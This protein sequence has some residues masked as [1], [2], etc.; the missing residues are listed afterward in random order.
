M[1]KY[2]Q[3]AIAL[4]NSDL[5][6]SSAIY[7]LI[8]FVNKA[9]PFFL[10]PL[11]TRAFSL[12]EYGVFSIYRA[13]MN[14]SIPIVGLSLAEAVIR[15]YYEK[16]KVD[17][18]TYIFSVLFIN[19]LTIGSLLLITMVWGTELYGITR[20]SKELIIMALLISFFTSINN[21]ERGLFRCEKQNKLFGV[22]VVGQ[23]LLYFVLIFLLYFIHRLVLVNAVYAEVSVYAIFAVIGLFY[24]FKKYDIKPVISKAYIKTALSFSLPLV[25]NGIMAYIF[26]LSD[27]YII[28][29]QLG[30]KSVAIYSATFQ[31]TSVLQ[32]LA[33]SFITAWLHWIYESLNKKIAIL[34]LLK[35]QLAISFAFVIVGILFYIV[36][37]RFLP[38]IVGEK[39]KA[40][41]ILIG[42]FIGSNLLQALYQMFAPILQYYNKGWFLLMA[43]IP[44]FLFSVISNT[45]YLKNYGIV[46]ASKI[47]FISW[48]VIFFITL[49]CS[50][51]V[52][53]NAYKQSN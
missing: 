46:F 33:A 3:K 45:L 11:F 32:I 44:A 12:S 20:L 18:G 39:Y 27:R 48:F 17:F 36:V 42:W 37:N 51:A 28:N 49:I 34:K 47:N 41:L 7:T 24:L 9:F 38:L 31:L 35:I 13:T 16:E 19:V 22:V 8:N 6:K 15:K 53:K 23:S 25:L 52:L 43:S 21:I 26:A 2:F 30:E 4:K 50:L 29:Y 40:G 5:L 14:I 10:L 1:N